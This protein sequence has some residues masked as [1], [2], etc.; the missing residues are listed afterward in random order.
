MMFDTRAARRHAAFWCALLLFGSP[1]YAAEGISD[2][3]SGKTIR[4]ICGSGPGGGRD[5]YARLLAQNISRHIPG[6]PSVIVQDMDGAGGVVAA[7]YVYNAAPKDGTYIA[8]V[9]Q[10]MPMYQML[11]GSGAKFDSAK[12]KWIGSLVHSNELVYTWNSSGIFT[13]EDAKQRQVAL[14]G[15]GR[16]SDSYVYPT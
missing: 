13:L 9:N 6:H 16:T 4:I 12:L 10:N 5:L 14:G 2:F 15:V 1:A 11:G 7:N 3:Y 8:T